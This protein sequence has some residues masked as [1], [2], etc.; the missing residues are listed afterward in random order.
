M[1]SLRT[2]LESDLAKGNWYARS[3]S[4]SLV[5]DRDIKTQ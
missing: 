2:K 4:L 1:N 5:N 3:I